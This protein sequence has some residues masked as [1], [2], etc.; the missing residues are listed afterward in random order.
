M[1]APQRAAALA[2]MLLLVG[3]AARRA[4]ASAAPAGSPR[5]EA[6]FAHAD[7]LLRAGLET[8]MA[9]MTR[10][11]KVGKPRADTSEAMARTRGEADAYAARR[12][13]AFVEACATW[14][15]EKLSCVE[16][17]SAP[18][19][20]SACGEEPLVKGFTDEVVAVFSRDPL[21]R[22]APAAPPAPAGV[23]SETRGPLRR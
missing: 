15:E 8:F 10:Y 14:P 6:A 23:E 17:A 22:A 18:P 3:C 19:E 4:P 16:A 20:L 1:N 21:W 9:D 2:A 11:V 13:P 5:C 12:R 7:T